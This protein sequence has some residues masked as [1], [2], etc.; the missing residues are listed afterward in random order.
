MYYQGPVINPAVELNIAV[1]GRI[2]NDTRRPLEDVLGEV[3]TL[4]YRPRDAG[5]RQKLVEL[6][7][8]AEDAY[9]GR[10]DPTRFA[11]AGRAMPGELLL[12]DLFGTEPGPPKYLVEP[13]LDADGRKEYA[14]QLIA[15]LRDLDGLKSRCDDEGR[16]ARI[17]K[18]IT[19]VLMFLRAISMTEELKRQQ[20]EQR[21]NR[22]KIES[23]IGAFR[24]ANRE[25]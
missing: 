22:A 4:Y 8:R 12:S 23:R 1:G 17:E 3:V 7:L 10:W 19:L 20:E 11:A 25:T 18:A 13:F 15:I 24:A 2:L 9:F 21:K 5:T 14:N 16:L 6:F